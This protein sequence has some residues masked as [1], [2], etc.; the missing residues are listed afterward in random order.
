MLDTNKKNTVSSK[1]YHVLTKGKYNIVLI[2][3]REIKE[4]PHLLTYT[5]IRSIKKY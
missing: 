3:Y 4:T 1:L 5:K 2:E